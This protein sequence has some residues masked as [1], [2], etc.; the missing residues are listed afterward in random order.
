VVPTHAEAVKL[1]DELRQ[2]L[3][4]R[5]ALWRGAT[6]RIL[7][8]PL[9]QC[10]QILLRDLPLHC[11]LSQMRPLLTRQPLPLNLGHASAAEYQSAEFIDKTILL[12]RIVIGKILL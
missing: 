5:G 12:S 10:E 4:E 6:Y 1:T 9:S 8:L 11:T 3:K 2:A 7:H